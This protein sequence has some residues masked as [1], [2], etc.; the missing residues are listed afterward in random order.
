MNGEESIQ[1]AVKILDGLMREYRGVEASD[2]P[3]PYDMIGR[4]LKYLEEREQNEE[5]GNIQIYMQGSEMC[6]QIVARKIMDLIEDE[7]LIPESVK[8]FH[9]EIV[10]DIEP[11]EDGWGDDDLEMGDDDDE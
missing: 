8:N 2:I 3:A 6:K 5:P 11:D 10:S 4:A 1:T 7:D 9:L